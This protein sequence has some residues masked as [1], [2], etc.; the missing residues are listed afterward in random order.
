MMSMANP[1]GA[2]GRRQGRFV[3]G[4]ANAIAALLR[5]AGKEGFGLAE[6]EFGYGDSYHDIIW[7]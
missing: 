5:R 6:F 7:A 1:P 2:D 3:R 4:R